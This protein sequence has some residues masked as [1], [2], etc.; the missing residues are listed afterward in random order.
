M[1]IFNALF[2][3]TL[4]I[5]VFTCTTVNAQLPHQ[6][7]SVR[8]EEIK[9]ANLSISRISGTNLPADTILLYRTNEGRY[10]KV[11]IRTY[12]YNLTL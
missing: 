3:L 5:L 1:K 11:L 8:L 2:F 7:D 6:F 9:S 10:G 12:G 4:L